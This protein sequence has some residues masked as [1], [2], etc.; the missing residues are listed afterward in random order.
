MVRGGNCG[1]FQLRGGRQFGIYYGGGGAY[2]G[3]LISCILKGNWAAKLVDMGMAGQGGG[4]YSAT[5]SNCFLTGNVGY[6]GGAAASSTEQMRADR[7]RLPTAV[8]RIRATLDNC[9]LTGNH[10]AN[11]GGAHSGTFSNC[12]LT[13]NLASDTGGGTSFATLNNCILIDN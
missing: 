11:G 5:L 1:G 10:A 7:Q 12:T 4:A 13:N 8:E 3:T 9:S 6:F 2:G